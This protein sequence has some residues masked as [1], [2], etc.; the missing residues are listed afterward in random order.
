M[1]ASTGT[2]QLALPVNDKEAELGGEAERLAHLAGVEGGGEVRRRSASAE[3]V[4]A[5]RLLELDELGV[6]QLLRQSFH[7]LPRNLAIGGGLGARFEAMLHRGD[8]AVEVAQHVV[9]E[10]RARPLEHLGARLRPAGH[11]DV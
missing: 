5:I 10:E 3:E 2:A 1:V 6:R 11:L 9:C 7:R 4:V 8:A